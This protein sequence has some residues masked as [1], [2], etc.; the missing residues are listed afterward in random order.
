MSDCVTDIP[1]GG[2]ET[3]TDS[4]VLYFKTIPEKYQFEEIVESVRLYV[5]DDDENR[6]LKTFRDVTAEELLSSAYGVILS[7]WEELPDNNNYHIIGVLNLNEHYEISG[8]EAL[9]SYETR[10]VR[11]ENHEISDDLND[12]FIGYIRLDPITKTVYED[13]IYLEKLTNRIYLTV[14]FFDFELPA[15]TEL[16]S[17]ITGSN[18]EYNYLNNSLGYTTMTYKPHTY[19]AEHESM[20]KFEL[21]TG[22]LYLEDDLVL[23]IEMYDVLGRKVGEQSINLTDRIAETQDDNGNYLYNTNQK[24]QEEDEFYLYLL[25]D[26]NFEIIEFNVNDWYLVVDPGV[27]L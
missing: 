12:I 24:L 14:E 18:S 11:D 2:E 9:D 6:Y 16:I 3:E 7:E 15:G 1:G 26:G 27:D 17:Y 13:T 19:G 23:W 10:I 5:Y 25:I 8:H 21:T 22:K 4:R 20:F